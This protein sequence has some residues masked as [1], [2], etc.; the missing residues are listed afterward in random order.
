VLIL[1]RAESLMRT[2]RLTSTPLKPPSHLSS[3][4]IEIPY[5]PENIRNFCIIAHIDHGKSTLAD[6]LLEFTKTVAARDMQEQLLDNMDIERERGITIKLQAARMVYNAKNGK[7]YVLNLID[8]PGHVDFGY[9]VSR[10]LAACE[11]A[12]LVVDASQGVEAQTM[13]NAYLAVENDL[14]IIPVINKI[15]LPAADPGKVSQEVESTVGLDCSN[16]IRASAKMGLGIEDILEAIVENMPA[17]R[18][19]CTK[20][21]RALIFD[22]YYDAYRGV[23]VFFRVIDGEIKKGDKIRFMASGMEYEVLEVGVMT[24]AQVKVDVLR[25]GEVG[26][27]SAAIRAVD[28]A[29]VGDTIAVGGP[30]K[31][32]KLDPLPGYLPAKPMVFCGLYPTESDDYEKLRDAIGKLKLNDAAL[33]YTPETS[34]AMGFGFRCGFLG[35]LH[36]DIIQE[37]LEREYS[38]DL[39]VT[40]PSVVYKVVMNGEEKE[41]RYIDT[42]AKLPDP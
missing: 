7:K 35:L 33:S 31:D 27:M 4:I 26:F 18:A 16:A 11:G 29:R 34:S 13:A 38:L 36:M 25:A 15:D 3:S 20:P 24:P 17:P 37:R 39:I 12:L 10:S 21:L 32:S 2:P 28:H 6:R 8:T 19:D 23:V 5:A 30:N 42:P 40:A 22:S 41:E 1:F 14:E 9:E